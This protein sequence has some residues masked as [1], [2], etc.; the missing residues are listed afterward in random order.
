MTFELEL[1]EQLSI[2]CTVHSDPKDVM[3]FWE[4][5][6]SSTSTSSSASP[7]AADMSI[8]VEHS[9]N[10]NMN[11]ND[12]NVLDSSFTSENQQQQ[13]HPLMNIEN[14]EIPYYRS[15]IHFRPSSI[16]HFGTFRFSLKHKVH[17]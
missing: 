8:I 5:N 9:N 1:F 7:T 4:F 17:I 3:F 6:S 14:F 16:E 11:N 15:V 2:E 13:K 12:N 10:N